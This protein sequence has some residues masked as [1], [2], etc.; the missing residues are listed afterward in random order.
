MTWA[1]RVGDLATNIALVAIN[2]IR[3]VTLLVRLLAD[4]LDRF[5]TALA[6][7]GEEGIRRTDTPRTSWVNLPASVFWGI[8]AIILRVL[9]IATVFVRQ[10]ATTIDEFFRVLAEG[11]QGTEA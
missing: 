4:R 5:V 2:L 6:E 1:E 8:A 10:L 9:S 3:I 7:R 11:E